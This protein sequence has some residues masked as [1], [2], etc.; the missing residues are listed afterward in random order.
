[1]SVRDPAEPEPDA[2]ARPSPARRA[3][4]QRIRHGGIVPDHQTLDAR[5]VAVSPCLAA[6]PVLEA[7]RR[8]SEAV[9][10]GPGVGRSKYPKV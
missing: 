6:L 4:V 7:S 5:G 10:Q 3:Q 1:M 8:S 2:P 9:K